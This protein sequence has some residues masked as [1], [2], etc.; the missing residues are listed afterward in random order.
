MEY[1]A[2]FNV[3]KTLSFIQWTQIIE[4]R[5]PVFFWK[6]YNITT[7]GVISLVPIYKQYTPQD[8]IK[9]V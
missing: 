9:N 1:S 6:K 3:P 8:Y 2:S 7:W 4:E 5:I